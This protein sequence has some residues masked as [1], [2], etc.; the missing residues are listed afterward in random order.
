MIFMFVVDMDIFYFC[1]KFVLGYS[2]ILRKVL[3]FEVKED[4]INIG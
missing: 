3:D 1:K 2:K 4:D